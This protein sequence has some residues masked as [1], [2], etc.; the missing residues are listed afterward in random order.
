MPLLRGRKEMQVRFTKLAAAATVLAAMALM[1]PGVASAQGHSAIAACKQNEPILC[2]E[3]NQV[4]LPVGGWGLLLSEAKN[5]KFEGTLSE[6][7]SSSSIVVKTSESHT[8]PIKG[9]ITSLVFSG[10]KPC[11]TA[12]SFPPYAG[13]LSMTNGSEDY[14]VSGAGSMKLSG[15]PFGVTCKFGTSSLELL[16]KN[17]KTGATLFAEKETFKLEEGSAFFCGSTGTWTGTYTAGSGH[18]VDSSG[19]VIET[20]KQGWLSLVL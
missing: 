12:T 19:K 15:C 4:F 11:T 9:E 5:V 7:C 16:V 8:N 13:S 6:E 18:V 10:C 17:T 20:Y 1:V 14:V 2:S 3:K